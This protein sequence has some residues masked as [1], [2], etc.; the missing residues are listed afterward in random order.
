MVGG[1]LAVGYVW[2][3]TAPIAAA[4]AVGVVMKGKRLVKRIPKG[5]RYAVSV[6]GRNPKLNALPPLAARKYRR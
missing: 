4:G 2:S 6:L 3:N 5:W 1:A